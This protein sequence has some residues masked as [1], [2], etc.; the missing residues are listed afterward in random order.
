MI[1]ERRD[2][3]EAMRKEVDVGGETRIEA[4]DYRR[5]RSLISRREC[6]LDQAVLC[7]AHVRGGQIHT[8]EGDTLSPRDRQR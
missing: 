1:R 6:V 7:S 4:R 3:W 8:L 2:E 5:R